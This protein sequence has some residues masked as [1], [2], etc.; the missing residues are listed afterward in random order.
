MITIRKSIYPYL[1]FL[2]TLASCSTAPRLP[3]EISSV[4][5]SQPPVVGKLVDL[6]IEVRSIGDEPDV[7]V[8]LSFPPAIHSMENKIKWD[9]TLSDNDPQIL[10]TEICVLEEGSWAID[11]GI[12]AYF[13]DG[14]FKYG[15]QGAIG[16]ISTEDTAELLLEKDI[17]F[18]QAEQTQNA[19][20]APMR[21]NPSECVKP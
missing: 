15:D 12:A 16:L 6:N 1:I 20:V 4:S 17:S 21:V 18:S 10:S 9:L 5:A 11:V 2:I 14:E 19:P 7:I 8:T 13:G 3:I